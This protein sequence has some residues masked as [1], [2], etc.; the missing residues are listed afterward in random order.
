M[1]RALLALLVPA[2]LLLAA[3]AQ[4]DDERAGRHPPARIVFGETEQSDFQFREI[5]PMRRSAASTRQAYFGSG[6][7]YSEMLARLQSQMT[8]IRARSQLEHLELTPAQQAAKGE[9]VPAL[10]RA[11]ALSQQAREAAAD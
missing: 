10:V 1:K 9:M 3:G 7:L 4:A 2:L 11:L 6:T 8:A 5:R